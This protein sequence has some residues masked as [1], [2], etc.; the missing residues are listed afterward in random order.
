MHASQH[1]KRCAVFLVLAASVL[2]A[3]TNS[4]TRIPATTR[5]EVV[6][7]A[8][9]LAQHQWTCGSKNIQATCSARY[10]SDWKTGQVVTGLPY[11][12][13]KMDSPP[14]FDHKLTQGYAAGGHSQL[15][16]LSCTAGIDCSGFVTY[17]WGLPAGNH[18]YTTGSLRIIAGK[19]KYNWF[20]DMKP[21]DALDKPGSHVV[22]F[23][24][25]NEDGTINV[26]EASGSAARVVCHATT[27]SRY[28]GYI[29]LQYKGIDD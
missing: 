18:A 27:W 28:K 5:A 25:Y 20:S 3:Q 21:G 29:P 13:G 24:G 2:R 17:C 4:V 26:C 22:L 15:G 14:M 7:R 23:M 6:R 12:W 1:W 11:G 9:E 16:V 10:R 19:P 8:K